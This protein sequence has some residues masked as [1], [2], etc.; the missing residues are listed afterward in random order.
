LDVINERN[1]A[2]HLLDEPLSALL[3]ESIPSLRWFWVARRRTFCKGY[4]RE[5]IAKTTVRGQR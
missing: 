4:L 2:A 5:R 1:A 3:T